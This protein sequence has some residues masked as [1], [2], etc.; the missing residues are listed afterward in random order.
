[1]KT[2]RIISTIT[3]SLP[4]LV[5]LSLLL[6]AIFSYV[7]TTAQTKTKKEIRIEEAEYLIYDRSEV[8]NAQRL[9]KNVKLS[10][11][12]IVM[13]CDSA[14]FYSASNSVDAFGNVHIISNDTLNMYSNFINYKGNEGMAKAIGKVKLKDPKLTLTTDTLDFDTKSEIGYYNSGGK[15]IDSTNVLTSIIGRYYSQKNEL[16]F[17]DSVKLVNKDYTMTSDTMKYNTVSEIVTILGPTHIIGDSSYLYSEKGWFD[18]KKN[19][20]ELLKNSTIR[21]GESQLQGD[22]IYYEDITGKGFARSNVVINDF[23]NKIII[24]GDN[25]VYNDF[26]QNA[27]M[28]DSALFIQYFN[29]DSLFLHADT[30][31]TKPDTSEINQKLVICYNKVR[32]YKSDLQGLSDSLIYFTKDSTIQLFLNPVIWSESNQLSADFIEM[33]NYE[34]PPNKVFLKENSFIIQEMD[35]LK[36]NQI[37]GKNMVGLIG[38]SNNLYQINVSGNGQSIYYPSDDKDFVGV[39]KAESSNIILYLNE[40]KINRISFITTPVGTMSPIK[41]GLDPETRLEGFKWRGKVR[42]VNKYDIFR[43]EDSNIIPENLPKSEIDNKLPN[44]QEIK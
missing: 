29:N 14:W 20:S 16:F 8:Q 21:R 31:F 3:K 40:N 34:K 41:I 37:K 10:H 28:T 23:K 2:Y 32:F 39:N 13:Y 6:L 30:L 18:T 4:E 15:I 43:T 1:M 11:E 19:I 44:P 33:K 12:N 42:P 27:L 22:Y 38:E 36:Y 24:A 9:I 26:T 35:S 17:K 5:R 25:A 7:S